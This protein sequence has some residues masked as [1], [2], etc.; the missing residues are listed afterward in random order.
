[1][2]TPGGLSWQGGWDEPGVLS[3]VIVASGSPG[4]GVFVYSGTPGAGNGP[5]GWITASTTDP[6]GNTV[7]PGIMLAEA[8]ASGNAEGGLIWNTATPGAAEPLL[9]LYPDATVGFT[10]NSPFILGR[11]FHR[12]TASES[13]SLALGGGGSSGTSPVMLELFGLSKDGT[14]QLNELIAYYPLRI[15][16][17]D[18]N[19]YT[20]G[21]QILTATGQTISSTSATPI[22][23]LSANVGIG[24]YKVAGSIR[25]VAAA[26]GTAQAFAIQFN[27]TTTVLSGC[28]IRTRSYLESTGVSMNAGT[29]SGLAATGGS[30]GTMNNGTVFSVDFEG[31]ITVST[32]GTF[33]V[34][35]LQVTSAADE[36]FTVQ[37][38]SWMEL[39]PQ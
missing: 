24:T 16:P 9:A 14:S 2:S 25:V 36:T 22:T 1:M 11:V 13:V 35:G 34:D 38:L 21:H 31:I 4:T 7:Q 19:T 30:T 26:S 23:G 27:G 32:A 3:V 20:A 17:P 8:S 12:G 10:G 28:R 29:I 37:A 15:E 5:I 18:G 33:H 6:Y 39:T